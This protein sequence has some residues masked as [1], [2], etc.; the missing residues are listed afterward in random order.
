LVFA[1]LNAIQM[2]RLR[3]RR[4]PE[5][6]GMIVV[7][8][9]AASWLVV[10]LPLVRGSGGLAGIGVPSRVQNANPSGMVAMMMPLSWTMAWCRLQSEMRF[11]SLVLP[12]LD[13]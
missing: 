11:P 10:M 12:P 6:G 5:F 4:S 3:S 1:L 13:Q 7:G 2:A 8:V 9:I